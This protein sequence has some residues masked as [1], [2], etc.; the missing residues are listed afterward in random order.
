MRG[1]KIKC[2]LEF[3]GILSVTIE[4]T[5]KQIV[6]VI[7]PVPDDKSFMLLFVQLDHVIPS[8]IHF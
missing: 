8:M 5:C 2:L 4:N 1:E 3:Y 7:R 6:V